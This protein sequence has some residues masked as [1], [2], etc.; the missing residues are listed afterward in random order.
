MPFTSLY[1][2]SKGSYHNFFSLVGVE[3][4][5]FLWHPLLQLLLLLLLQKYNFEMLIF[6]VQKRVYE[7][8]KEV[9]AMLDNIMYSNLIA[10]S[11]TTFNWKGRYKKA[12]QNGYKKVLLFPKEKNFSVV[13]CN[14]KD[15][16]LR[17]AYFRIVA[18]VVQRVVAVNNT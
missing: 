8:L 15:I 3:F 6:I 5:A 12:F 11:I 14:Y 4:R 9:S 2:D 1:A 18:N 16:I 7:I 10:F 13:S 17:D